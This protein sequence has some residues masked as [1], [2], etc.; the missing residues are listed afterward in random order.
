VKAACMPSGAAAS[1]T[2]T[3]AAAPFCTQ[4][5]TVNEAGWPTSTAV[6]ESC[7]LTHSSV[8]ASD[9]VGLADAVELGSGEA[10]AVGW[11]AGRG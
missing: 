4:T 7:T 11:A 1:V 8:A 9:A 2:V 3:C 6:L 5:C 10:D